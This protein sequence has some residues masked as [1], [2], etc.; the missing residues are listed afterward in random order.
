MM[1][2]VKPL[3]VPGSLGSLGAIAEYVEDVSRAGALDGPKAY[4]LRLA[5]DELATNII[6]HGYEENG[7]EGDLRFTTTVD[8]GAITM[9]VE[10]RGPAFDP[11][12]RSD[13]AGMDLPLEQRPIGGLGLYL[14]SSSVDETHYERDGDVN[15]NTLVVYRSS[16][17]DGQEEEG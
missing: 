17:R 2:Q 1:S 10:D 4:R 3:T 6:V 11:R 16:V 14:V 5:V 8:R 7:V 12:G 15:R 13:P 9:T